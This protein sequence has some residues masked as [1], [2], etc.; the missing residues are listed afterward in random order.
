MEVT[1]Y[2]GDLKGFPPEIVEKMLDRQE[3]QG[4]GR[5]IEVF[6]GVITSPKSAGGFNWNRTPEGYYFWNAV[7]RDRRFS[8][9]WDRY[10]ETIADGPVRTDSLAEFES[11]VKDREILCAILDIHNLYPQPQCYLVALLLASQFQGVIHHNSEHCVTQIDGHLYDKGGRIN[12][13]EGKF[14]KDGNY[15][16]L[17]HFGHR[18]KR[19]LVQAIFEKHGKLLSELG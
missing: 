6:E 8:I 7:I 9:F 18:V 5:D 10:H 19:R 4:N 1:D 13:P 17:S 3:Q 2:K 14:L 11:T 15:E 12:G 16:L